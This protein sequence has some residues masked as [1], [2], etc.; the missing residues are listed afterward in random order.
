MEPRARIVDGWLLNRALDPL[1]CFLNLCKN[2]DVVMP[3]CLGAYGA[4]C[5]IKD[6]SAESI[7][8]SLYSGLAPASSIFFQALVTALPKVPG[9]F[10]TRINSIQIHVN[11]P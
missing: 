2:H 5:V 10:K 4:D 3:V 7:R 8:K 9:C 11:T 1:V 6:V